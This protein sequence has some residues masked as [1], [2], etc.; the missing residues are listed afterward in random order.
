MIDSL[1]DLNEF[2]NHLLSRGLSNGLLFHP[3]I[4]RSYFDYDSLGAEDQRRIQVLFLHR[5]LKFTEALELEIVN[6]VFN[7][8]LSGTS[9]FGSL[10]ESEHRLVQE[11]IFEEVVHAEQ[12][13][14]IRRLISIYLPPGF[15]FEKSPTQELNT[16]T[17]KWREQDLSPQ[18]I[19]F[20]YVFSSETLISKR[21]Q[22]NSGET[23]NKTVRQ[24]MKMH[25]VEEARHRDYFFHKMDSFWNTLNESKKRTVLFL[26]ADCIL[27]FLRVNPSVLKYDLSLLSESIEPYGSSENHQNLAKGTLQQCSGIL[28][29]FASKVPAATNREFN[30]KIEEGIY[31]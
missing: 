5:L 19:A 25:L 22:I 12:A 9:I 18:E 2:N 3:A 31:V 10:S 13:S 21:L 28:K 8:I 15:H 1:F 30:M 7:E 23:M 4:L 27:A 26:V 14:A 6:P 29:Y 17:S 24:Y 20:V 16:L 11:F